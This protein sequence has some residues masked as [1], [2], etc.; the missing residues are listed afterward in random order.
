MTYETALE[1]LENILQSLQESHVD[2]DSLHGK[3]ERADAL[4]IWCRQ[5]LRTVEEQLRHLSESAQQ[6]NLPPHA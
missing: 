2:I 4:L 6:N 5:R 1:E 3:V